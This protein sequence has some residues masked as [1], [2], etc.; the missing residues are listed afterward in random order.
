[1]GPGQ[2]RQWGSVR[3]TRLHARHTRPRVTASCASLCSLASARHDCRTLQ[4][5]QWAPP[6]E[7]RRRPRRRRRRRRRLRR[8]RRRTG[9]RCDRRS[10][11]MPTPCT[12]WS[13]VCPPSSGKVALRSKIGAEVG[14]RAHKKRASLPQ[15]AGAGLPILAPRATCFWTTKPTGNAT[16]SNCVIS[17][18][19]W[20][21]TP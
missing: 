7:A 11:L 16:G 15:G 17:A 13:L 8:Q 6:P 10:S 4:Q 21:A 20:P 5:R 14:A 2:Q 1:M 9:P 19:S 12:S 18:R 3:T